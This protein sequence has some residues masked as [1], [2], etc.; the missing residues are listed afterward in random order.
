MS[1]AL[2]LRKLSKSQIWSGLGQDRGKEMFPETIIHKIFVKKYYVKFALYEKS[3]VA[4][5]Q[6]FFADTNKIFISGGGLN[7]GQ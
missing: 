6:G 4:V 1:K 3:S 5:L 7:A 2:D